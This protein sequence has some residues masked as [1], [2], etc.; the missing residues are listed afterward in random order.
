MLVRSGTSR[1]VLLD[2]RNV[3]RGRGGHVD[4]LGILLGADGHGGLGGPTL[5]DNKV[6]LVWAEEGSAR[7][8]FRFLQVIPS[9]RTVLPMECSNSASAAA[10][11][12]QLGGQHDAVE[13][14]W[15]AV[16]LSTRQRV[17]LRPNHA[18][19]VADAW[20]VR[21]LATPKSRKALDGL[22]GRHSVRIAGSSVRFQPVLLG[23]LFLFTEADPDSLNAEA[24][25]KLAQAGM[26]VARAAG[27]R[28]PRGYCPKLIPYQ[29]KTGGQSPVVR[30]ASFYHGERH[31]SFPGSAAMALC[32]WLAQQT[33]AEQPPCPNWRLVH[34]S[35][36]IEVRLGFTSRQGNAMLQWA[37]FVTPVELLAWGCAAMPWR[38]S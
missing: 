34:P 17:V 16:N 21:F 31:R 10:M 36:E 15:Q 13:P 8:S 37:E 28:P 20:A 35:G 22:S 26:R 33:A 27:F 12:A 11:L 3:R 25:G 6:A 38:N 19:G 32:A 5:Q 4:V 7:F 23:N 29:L 30:A 14:E 1:I 9:N 2:G 18:S 24:Q